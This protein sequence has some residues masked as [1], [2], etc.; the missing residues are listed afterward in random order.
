MSQQASSKTKRSIRFKVTCCGELLGWIHRPTL[1]EAEALAKV[2]FK[3]QP[4]EVVEAD[5]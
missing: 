1:K 3:C 2:I 4:V 5:D